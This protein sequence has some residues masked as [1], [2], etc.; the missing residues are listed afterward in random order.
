MSHGSASVRIPFCINCPADVLGLR[1]WCILVYWIQTCPCRA[2]TLSR[3]GEYWYV[4]C[5][6]LCVLHSPRGSVHTPDEALI[7]HLLIVLS[8]SFQFKWFFSGFLL[9][10]LFCLNLLV[11][12][13]SLLLNKGFVPSADDMSAIVLAPNHS[14]HWLS[15]YSVCK[16][17][18]NSKK[19]F[20][21]GMSLTLCSFGLLVGKSICILWSMAKMIVVLTQ[22]SVVIWTSS[23]G[24][25][26]SAS[27]T[28]L[29]SWHSS[30]AALRRV[31]VWL[32]RF[33][34]L[35]ITLMCLIFWV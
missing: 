11:S 14:L 13:S 8:Q 17:S 29:S 33:S 22:L 27:I 2:R 5:F 12:M 10:V 4:H 30:H 18:S 15:W 31:D 3:D 32:F 21:I 6:P 24:P 7:L 28:P 25:F 16:S 1:V 26:V 35:I 20:I 19:A 23:F 9:F 34:V